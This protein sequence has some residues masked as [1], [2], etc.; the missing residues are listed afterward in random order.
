MKETFEIKNGVLIKYDGDETDVCIPN[1]VTSI[2]KR[3][4]YRCSHLKKV[5]IPGSVT[6]IAEEALLECRALK[7]II[8]I[9]GVKII[10][11]YA[12]DYLKDFAYDDGNEYSIRITIPASVTEIHS[13]SFSCW[14]YDDDD[15]ESGDD[16]FYGWFG[17][18]DKYNIFIYCYQ[19]TEA[20]RFAIKRDFKYQLLPKR[21]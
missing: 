4:F 21:L 3:A 19:D 1:G 7:E 12:F 15:D 2:G 9:E 14:K 5:T 10:N 17:I 13:D 20:E 16:M 6:V 11:E 8:M 18:R